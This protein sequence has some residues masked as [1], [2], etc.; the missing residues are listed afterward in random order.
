MEFQRFGR[1]PKLAG[2]SPAHHSAEVSNSLAVDSGLSG[3]KT[4]RAV[5]MMKVSCVVYSCASHL[6]TKRHTSQ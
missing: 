3:V 4:W 1:P 2:N 5:A 6:V